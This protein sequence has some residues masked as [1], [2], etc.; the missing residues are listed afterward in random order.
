MADFDTLY[1]QNHRIGEMANVLSFLI[2]DRQ[3]CDAD[4]TCKLFFQY[5]N[6]VNEHLD[7]EERTLYKPLLTHSATRKLAENFLGGSAEIKRVFKQYVRHWCKN[8]E[9]HIKDHQE[10]LDDT[11]KMFELIWNRIVDESEKLYPA[12]KKAEARA[13]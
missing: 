3:M 4:I 5:V 2:K 12:V 6:A 7:L 9:L 13:A 1:E 11:N 8:N 10:F